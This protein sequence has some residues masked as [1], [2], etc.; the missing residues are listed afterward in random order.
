MRWNATKYIIEKA[1]H[2][3]VFPKTTT[4]YKK[5]Q[6][7]VYIKGEYQES[8]NSKFYHIVRHWDIC[9]N[10]IKD[11]EKV[12]LHYVTPSFQARF[13]KSRPT[14]RRQVINPRHRTPQGQSVSKPQ[15]FLWN[16]LVTDRNMT[17]RDPKVTYFIQYSKRVPRGKNI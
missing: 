5:C 15:M 4:T 8:T 17:W 16:M 2:F 12:V 10:M 3:S 14:Y 11:N 7:Y 1:T 9:K 6:V 13:P